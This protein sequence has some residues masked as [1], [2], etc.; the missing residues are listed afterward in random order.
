MAR[1]AKRASAAVE[2]VLGMELALPAVDQAAR[3]APSTDELQRQIDDIARRHAAPTPGLPIAPERVL[4]EHLPPPETFGRWLVGQI[5][6]EDEVVYLAYGAK[7]DPSFPRSATVEGVRDYLRRKGASW[8]AFEQL[9]IA[10]A[11][12]TAFAC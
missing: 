6:R 2:H 1:K 9:D 10:E 5:A 8:E 7:A 3:A 11:A 4:D 12:F